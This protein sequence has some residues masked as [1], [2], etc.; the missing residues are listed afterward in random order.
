[1]QSV[2]VAGAGSPG[3]RLKSVSTGSMAMTGVAGGF[4]G[5]SS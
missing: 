3:A 2:H 1:M 5:S 4:A